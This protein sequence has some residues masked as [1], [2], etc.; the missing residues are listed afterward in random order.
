MVVIEEIV[1]EEGFSIGILV[2]VSSVKSHCPKKKL[3]EECYL[4]EKQRNL[5]RLLLLFEVL[6]PMMKTAHPRINHAPI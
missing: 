4:G 6:H 2:I 3:G 5:E 1:P